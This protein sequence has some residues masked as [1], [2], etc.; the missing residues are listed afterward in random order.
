MIEYVGE[1][2]GS[3]VLVHRFGHS[4]TIILVIC[5][6]IATS[7]RSPSFVIITFLYTLFQLGAIFPFACSLRLAH[8]DHEENH[9]V[10]TTNY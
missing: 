10:A 1:G 5:S 6:F 3:S 4:D 9:V 2:G 7:F 8:H